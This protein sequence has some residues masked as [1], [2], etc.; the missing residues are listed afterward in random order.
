MLVV[1][2]EVVV[3]MLLASISLL[4]VENHGYLDSRS[5]LPPRNYAKF[6]ISADLQAHNIPN[7]TCIPGCGRFIILNWLFLRQ[8][9]TN[10]C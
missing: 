2:Y 8:A 9:A 10:M 3:F 6:T 5:N 7:L 4:S 1:D